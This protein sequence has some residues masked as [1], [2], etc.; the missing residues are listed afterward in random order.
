[1]SHSHEPWEFAKVDGNFPGANYFIGTRGDFHRGGQLLVQTVAGTKAD[2]ANA[3]RIVACING[4]ANLNPTAYRECVEVL[5]RMIECYEE[6][7]QPDIAA[8][9]L[10]AART[11]IRHAEGKDA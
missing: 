4:C 7:P 6:Q 11:A 9:C 1:M 5:S 8:G 10:E 2:E 3:A